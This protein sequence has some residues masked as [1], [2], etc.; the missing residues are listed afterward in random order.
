MQ[1][2]SITVGATRKLPHPTV[3]YAGI[4]G[5]VNITANVSDADDLVKCIEDLQTIADSTVMLHLERTTASL[6]PQAA[7]PQ[8]AKK[9][10]NA[11]RDTADRLAQ[12]YQEK[13][14]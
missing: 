5:M 4:S 3:D 1:I 13:K 11:T 12:K 9:S 6:Q 10:A 8:P 2:R 14:F 7:L